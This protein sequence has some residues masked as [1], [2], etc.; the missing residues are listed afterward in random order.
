MIP[1]KSKPIIGLCGGIASGKSTVSRLL[2]AKGAKSIDSDELA[3]QQLADPDV[4]NTFRSWWGRQVVTND[5]QID[6]RAMADVIF[7][8]PEQRKRME[9]VIYPRI[10][11]KRK[12]LLAD[13]E[14]DPDVSVIV[15]DSP[16]LFETGLNELCDAVVFVDSDERL[17]RE[18]AM[19]ERGW[20]GQ[21][22]QRR[23]AAQW[24]VEVKKE[25]SDHVVTNNGELVELQKNIEVLWQA[26]CP[27]GDTG[28]TI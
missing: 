24:T 10:A 13:Y 19:S 7:E 9:S 16:L 11:E 8:N 4:V 28:S 22:W 21:E 14:A 26:I 12:Q 23:E 15:I 18:R 1:N 25:R 27:N 2:Q 6:R 5:G 3:R 17:R 20:S